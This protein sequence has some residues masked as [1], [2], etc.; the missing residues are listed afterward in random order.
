MPGTK[1]HTLIPFN[2]NVQ[3][4]KSNRQKANEW[5][6]GAGRGREQQVSAAGMGFWVGVEKAGIR[7]DVVAAQM[8]HFMVHELHFEY[9]NEQE[10]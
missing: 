9:K 8:M 7:D 4:G 5:L 3:K 10:S 2:C 6:P 1:G